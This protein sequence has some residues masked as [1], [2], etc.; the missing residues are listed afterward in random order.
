MI[1]IFFRLFHLAFYFIIIMQE[2]IPSACFFLF[3]QPPPGI[4]P[5]I[6]QPLICA[7]PLHAM[8]MRIVRAFLGITHVRV[9]LRMNSQRTN[10]A[11]RV[12]SSIPH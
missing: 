2:N 11:V 9:H 7:S 10:M 3:L 5:T 12:S 8:G 6:L 4:Y 1:F